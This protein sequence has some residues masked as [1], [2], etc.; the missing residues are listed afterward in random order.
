MT[1]PDV[2][3]LTLEEKIGQMCCFGWGGADSLYRL[4]E[5]ARA[6]IRGMKAGGLIVMGRNVQPAGAA[7][8][9]GAEG[10][11]PVD[12]RAVRAMLDEAL[13][14]ADIPLLVATDQEG[15]RVARLRAPF[16]PFP[17][18]RVVGQAGD[19]GLAREAARVTA[20]ELRQVGINWNF[21]PVADVNSNPANPVIGDRAFGTTPETATP[22][23]EA[24]IAGLRAGGVLSCAKHFPG[25]G[26]TTLDSHYD[27]PTVAGDLAAMEARELVPFRAAVE[28]GVDAIMTAH[29]LFP[30][31]DPSGLPA[32]MSRL[33]L[34]DL[35]RGELGFNGLVV[36]DC[37]E[38]KAVADRW[39]T[40]RAAL[41]AAQAGADL[42]LVCHTFER[43]RATYD[44]LLAAARS[45]ELPVERVDEAAGRILAA[46]RRLAP[47]PPLFDPARIGAPEHIAVA[48]AL[49]EKAGVP[50]VAP[51][52]PTTLGAEAPPDRPPSC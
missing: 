46:K 10:L 14:L 42:L 38:M 32:T 1:I 45:G 16:T 40:P 13:A 50:F 12:V 15:G 44:T 26:D 5:Q 8:G 30:A 17:A 37:L 47:P 24:Q 4:N 6:C 52:A 28:A 11:P 49:A 31:V 43:Q 22:F 36:T 33:I 35:L 20:V 48:R 51:A 2:S 7:P 25:H 21:A 27:L 34:T 3:V 18:A 39:G 41:L 9:T 29:I 23:V 19:P